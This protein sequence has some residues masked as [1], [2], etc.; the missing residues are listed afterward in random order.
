MLCHPSWLGLSTFMSPA[1]PLPSFCFTYLSQVHTLLLPRLPLVSLCQ[2]SWCLVRSL[3]VATW[4]SLV[5]GPVISSQESS[6][7]CGHR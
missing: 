5:Y 4:L 3:Q 7:C 6:L 2:R 1:L